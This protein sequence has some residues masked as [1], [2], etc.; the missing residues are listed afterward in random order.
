MI[1]LTAEQAQQIVEAPAEQAEPEQYPTYGFCPICGSRGISRERRING[2]DICANGHSYASN[3]ALHIAPEKQA[4]QE[5][6]PTGATH[7]QPHQ[8][9]YYKRVSATEWYLW[10]CTGKGWLPSK[11]T[12]D[13]SEWIMLS[14]IQAHQPAKPAEQ[15]PLMDYE[16]IN[17]LREGEQNGAEDAYFFVR[18]ENDTPSLRKMFCQG[19]ERG[20]HK[21][22]KYA[23]P[24]S[25]HSESETD[26]SSS[27]MRTT[28]RTKDLTDEEIQNAMMPIEPTGK[29]YF[30]R[31]ARA[32]IAADRRKNK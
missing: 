23:A 8:K 24:V 26:S 19:F 15:E 27:S 25:I 30:L 18:P 9:T 16:R 32:V 20:F 10:S 6:V 12:S 5:P 11:G 31:L 22:L 1:T 7:Y 3:L 13:S 29:D 4:E 2:N 21:G 17:A 28:V 14:P